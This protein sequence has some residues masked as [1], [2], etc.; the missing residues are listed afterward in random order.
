LDGYF[1]D[2]IVTRGAFV[3]I[4]IDPWYKTK[5]LEYLWD[6]DRGANAP[7]IK[8]AV[9]YFRT[10]YTR[11]SYRAKNI[12]AYYHD[13]AINDPFG[14]GAVSAEVREDADAWRTDLLHGF[15]EFV[16]QIQ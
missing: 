8:K 1:K 16:Q 3:A 5:F 11:Y 10:I 9:E 7:K 13:L 12:T 4:L 14:L 15:G 2:S 6:A